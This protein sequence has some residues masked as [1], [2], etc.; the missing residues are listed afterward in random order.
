MIDLLVVDN[1]GRWSLDIPGVSVVSAREYLTEPT[2]SARGFR[3]H[4]LCRSFAYQTHGYYVSLLAEARGHRPH[5]DIVTIQD[6]RTTPI[7]RLRADDLDELIQRTLRTVRSDKFQLSVYFGETLAKRD[8]RLGRGLF[9]LFPAPL[10]RATFG[11]RDDHWTLLG[12][13]AI[14]ASEIPDSHQP[15]VLQAIGRYFS[16]RE[17]PQPAR[18]EPVLGWLGILIDPAEEQPPSDEGAIR[19]FS[20]AARRA[21]LGVELIER[22]DYGRVG[23]LDCLLI[24]TTTQVDHYTYRFARRAAAEGIAVIDDPLSIVRCTNKVFQTEVFLRNR[25]PIPPTLIVHRDNVDDVVPT[26]GLPCVLKVPDSS[27]S[28]GV[29]KVS[30]EE[31]CTARLREML[32]ESGLVIAQAFL[33]TDFDWRIGVLDGEPLYACR[34]HMARSHWQIL[35]R[36]TSGRVTS[37][38]VETL[39]I[40]EVPPR[41]VKAALRAARAMGKG[42]YGVDLKEVNGRPYVIE[43]NDNPNIDSG[44]EDAV[45]KDE[46]YQRVISSLVG[47][48]ERLR[49]GKRA[50]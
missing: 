26:L 25:V 21:G 44:V 6:L 45:L 20:Q 49:G 37:G 24:R 7:A 40:A 47:K 15:E 10:L 43:V 16:R 27:F 46:L 11:R 33:P 9:G 12:V 50:H 41:M 5:P 1:P 18:P 22:D 3:V 32:A 13:K 35:R 28:A 14:P 19:K 30:S 38:R 4:N 17:P 36:S 29:S 23:E 42:L 31:E 48:M 2:Y 34:Y 39:A 8:R